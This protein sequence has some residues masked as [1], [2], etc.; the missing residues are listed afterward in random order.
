MRDVSSSFCAGG[1]G[2]IGAYIYVEKTRKTYLPRY[3]EHRAL[4]GIEQRAVCRCVSETGRFAVRL[5]EV[6]RDA[7]SIEDTAATAASMASPPAS[8]TVY[9]ASNARLSAALY[10]ARSSGVER[11]LSMVP[12]PP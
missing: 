8:R 3:V 12:A 7:P 6:L 9:P 11:D 10:L 4:P 5:C 2:L 1:G